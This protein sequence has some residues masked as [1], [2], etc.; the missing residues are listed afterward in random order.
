MLTTSKM[1][2]TLTDPVEPSPPP[3]I[4][5]TWTLKTSLKGWLVMG[6]GGSWIVESTHPALQRFLEEIK[7]AL[8]TKLYYLAI[9]T[10]LSVPDVCSCLECSPN[11]IWTT[12]E[13]YKAWFDANLAH[14]FSNLTSDDCYRLRCG[15]LHKGNFGRP[16]SRS[17]RVIFMAP[18]P[19][20]RMTTDIVVTIAPGVSFGDVTGKVLQIEAVWFCQQFIDAVREWAVAK[21]ND[22]NVQT[23]VPNLVRLRPEGLP[24]YIVGVPLIA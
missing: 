23:N 18:N 21:I 14:R 10:T 5:R 7:T 4:E 11:A 19:S 6:I 2:E 17:D 22:P 8:D 9:A 1:V 12:P 13:K 15:V 20:F 16:D 3:H 24:P